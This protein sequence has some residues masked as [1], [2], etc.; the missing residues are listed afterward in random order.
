MGISLQCPGVKNLDLEGLQ[1]VI[2]T[3]DK[4]GEEG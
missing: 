3:G 4:T 1:K 2:T